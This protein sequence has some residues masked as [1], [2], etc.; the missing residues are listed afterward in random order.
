MMVPVRRLRRRFISFLMY[1]TRD[2]KTL[3][4]I[5]FLLGMLLAVIFQSFHVSIKP[6]NYILWQI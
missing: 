1:I 2:Q 5:S 4:G 3:F 6:I